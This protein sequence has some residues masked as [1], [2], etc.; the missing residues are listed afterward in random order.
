[1]TLRPTTSGAWKM[2]V[3]YIC[4]ACGGEYTSVDVFNILPFEGS[5][6]CNEC[7]ARVRARMVKAIE[8]EIELINYESGLVH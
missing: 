5:I 7:Y 2:T 1:M 8:D 4:D 6:I 3:K